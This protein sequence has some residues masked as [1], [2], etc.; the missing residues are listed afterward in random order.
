M[1]YTHY[2]VIDLDIDGEGD[3]K[4][5][6]EKHRQLSSSLEHVIEGTMPSFDSWKDADFT[7]ALCTE[8]GKK[9]PDVL[10]LKTILGIEYIGL[11]HYTEHTTEREKQS[12]KNKLN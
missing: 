5:L 1:S 9:E 11:A 7:L 10:I 8:D 4:E 12:A 6:E 2:Y 3:E